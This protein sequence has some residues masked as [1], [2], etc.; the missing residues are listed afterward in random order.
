EALRGSERAALAAVR[1][2]IVT[3][4]AT[5]RLL[6]SDYAVPA[7][8]ITVAL[9]GIDPVV[10]AH[11]SRDGTV[12]LLSVGALVPGKGYDVLLAAL[13]PVRDLPW[14]LTIAGARD[15]SPA[16]AAELEATIAALDLA[17]RVT[18]A[19]AVADARLA[20]LYREADLFVLAS[21]HEGY[22][23]AL[24]QAISLAA[25]LYAPHHTA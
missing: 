21:R 7:G 13:T 5:A 9:P 18:L 10:P 12:A 16:T 6:T 1:H 22:G 20:E 24:V 11:R 3:G 8:R 19:G 25:P 23:M 2:V 4:E 14:R 17:P 15:R